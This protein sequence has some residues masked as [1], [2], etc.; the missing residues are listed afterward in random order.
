[1]TKHR[2]FKAGRVQPGN[3]NPL[4]TTDGH[5]FCDGVG[6]KCWYWSV[7]LGRQERRNCFSCFP[8]FLIKSKC[9]G[10]SALRIPNSAGATDSFPVFILGWTIGGMNLVRDTRLILTF[11]PGRLDEE[12]C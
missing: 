12:V 8:V 1:M 7:E 6:G 5:E 11:Y 2:P 3:Q 4:S 10:G 9:G